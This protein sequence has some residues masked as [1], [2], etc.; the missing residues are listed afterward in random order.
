MCLV[1]PTI[2]CFSAV[3]EHLSTKPLSSLLNPNL[4]LLQK[5]DHQGIPMGDVVHCCITH[6]FS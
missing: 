2:Q 5:S 3:I 1:P 4:V 6:Y